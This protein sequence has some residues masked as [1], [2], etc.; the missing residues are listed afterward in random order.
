MLRIVSGEYTVSINNYSDLE[1]C[2]NVGFARKKGA[3]G[4]LERVK[5]KLLS[6]VEVLS[7]AWGS[8]SEVVKS[9][10]GLPFSLWGRS[11]PFAY[12][13]L[14]SPDAHR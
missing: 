13:C 4:P 7:Q 5:H 2:Q 6:V 1:G 3:Y 9:G 10:Q 11:R 14:T 8:E 12:G